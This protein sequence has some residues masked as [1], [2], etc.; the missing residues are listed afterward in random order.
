MCKFSLQLSQSGYYRV[1]SLLYRTSHYRERSN[2]RRY[3]DN[4]AGNWELTLFSVDHTAWYTS[5]HNIRK[6]THG[7]MEEIKIGV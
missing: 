1:T 4:G 5:R 2:V 6:S 7:D 3:R